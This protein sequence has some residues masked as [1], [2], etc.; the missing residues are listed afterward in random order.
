MLSGPPRIITKFNDLPL[1]VKTLL[2]D[3]EVPNHRY[4][5]VKID[6]PQVLG[7]Y[8]NMLCAGRAL[9]QIAKHETNITITEIP[10][11]VKPRSDR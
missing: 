10:L 6:D 5:I 1:P 4:V 9:V 3:I 8:E 2:K 11:K 7:F